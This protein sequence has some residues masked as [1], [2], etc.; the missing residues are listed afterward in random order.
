MYS[1][2][3]NPKGDKSEP[4][5]GFFHRPLGY[6][7]TALGASVFSVFIYV[8]L[9]Y[10]FGSGG[11][12][13]KALDNPISA[14][15]TIKA[16]P[17]AG[18]VSELKRTSETFRS[19]AKSV[20]PAVVTVKATQG[21]SKK[22][23]LK[24]KQRGGRRFHQQMPDD[25]GGEGD[26]P[27]RDFFEGFGLP[28]QMR[29]YP[30]QQMPQASMGSGVI[31]NSNGTLVTN[32]HV[33]KGATDVVVMVGNEKTELKAKVIGTDPRSDVAVLKIEKA[34][35]YPAVEWADS[36]AIEVGDWAI[37]IGSPFSLGQTFTLGIVSAKGRSAQALG[38]ETM[39]DLIQTDAA[40]NPGNSGGP[41]V[42]LDGK[43]MGINTAIYTRSGGYMGIGFAIPSNTAKDVADK[44]LK[45]G[46]V[47][48]GWLGVYIQPLS[49][50]LAKEM[51][52]EKGV[53][54]HEVVEDSPAAKAGLQAGDVIVQVDGKEVSEP[55]ELQKKISAFQPGQKVA[56]SY[57]S[58][59][60]KKKKSATVTIGNLA[61]ADAEGGEQKGGGG[62]GNSE[63]PDKI[64][65]VVSKSKE[66]LAVIKGVVPGSLAHQMGIEEGDVIEKINR[67][68][69]DPTTYRKEANKSGS[70]SLLI[71][72]KGN[73]NQTRFYQFTLP[74]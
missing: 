9:Q 56:I 18:G 61:D 6:F 16:A 73:K 21:S 43:V 64:G 26:D 32:N 39:G 41:L 20:G 52:V 36:D 62:D 72:K 51:G 74:E 53:G 50:E 27:L 13:E 49:P 34:G 4:Q 31:I 65:V 1:D 70:V 37:A 45:T 22:D 7:L 60:E 59:G 38:P 54:V 29:P 66:G 40:I 46:K 58:Y 44:L 2:Q 57:M 67:K 33:V 47:V 23:K 30:E 24:L 42:D 15:E 12:A 8:A 10:Y 11:S 28:F 17:L 19:I 48:R 3:E 68:R 35:K 55:A 5:K 63:E 71:R 14:A 69:A 25:E